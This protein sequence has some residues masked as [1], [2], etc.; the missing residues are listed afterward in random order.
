MLLSTVPDEW[1]AEAFNKGLNPRSSNASWKL[2]ESLLEF[3]VTI[4]ANVHN[5]Y[6]SKI[7]IEDDQIGFS[8]LAKGQEKNKEKSKDDFGIDR[9]SSRGQFFP[10]EWADGPGRGFWSADKFIT[11]RRTDR[12][13]NNKSL[14]DKEPSGSRILPIPGY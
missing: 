6:E 9:R 1:A 12:G 4:W 2:K 14:Q 3:Q 13:R 11:N 10:Y 8:A 7:R 5:R